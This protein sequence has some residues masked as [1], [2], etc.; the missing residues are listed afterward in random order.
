MHRFLR[1]IS[2]RILNLALAAGCLS[3]TSYG[4]ATSTVIA[5][6]HGPNAQQ[7]LSKHYVILVSLD[8]FRYD[9]AK[10]YHADHLLTLA[11]EGASAP[12][13]MLPA[14]PSITF[15]NHYTIV[16]GLYPE[17]HGII[18]NTI[19]DPGFPD[20]FTMSA[21]TAKDERWWGGEP[22]W[23]TAERQGQRAAAMFWPGTEVSFHNVRPTRWWP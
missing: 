6:D 1:Q 2:I 13:G 21:K 8:G 4:Q 18:A 20:R 19:A 12:E 11:A 5:V 22:I 17:H 7:Q 16:T 15:P 9:Y 3:A 23:I 14:Y 10:R